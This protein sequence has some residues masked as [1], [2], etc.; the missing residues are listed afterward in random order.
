M[1]A[2]V[3]DPE[4]RNPII[5]LFL[6]LAFVAALG[7]TAF[8]Y[9]V[10]LGYDQ[11]K[12]KLWE[13]SGSAFLLSFVALKRI[14]MSGRE[15]GLIRNLTWLMISVPAILFVYLVPALRSILEGKTLQILAM[16]LAGSCALLFFNTNYV[17][18]A[19]TLLGSAAG[20]GIV[21]GNTPAMLADRSQ[22]KYGGTSPQLFLDLFRRQ[23]RKHK[24]CLNS[25]VMRLT[26]S[27]TWI[28]HCSLAEILVLRLFIP[29][30]PCS[31]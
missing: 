31:I 6:A 29:V 30:Y 16:F 2:L 19:L 27:L 10:R 9:M 5:A 7:S 11:V 28:L 23:A 8:E 21:D 17:L 22:E 1:V 12:Q 15:T 14:A 25:A 13:Q 26:R 20:A 18:L 24:D 4:V 3:F